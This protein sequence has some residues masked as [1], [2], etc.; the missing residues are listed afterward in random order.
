MRIVAGKV[1]RNDVLMDDSFVPSEYLSHD[2]W[3]PEVVPEGHYFVMGD[4]RYLYVR[5]SP[6]GA[7]ALPMPVGA[8]GGICHSSLMINF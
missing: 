5:R 1:Y 3:G 4:N 7:L 6:V 2:D 8:N